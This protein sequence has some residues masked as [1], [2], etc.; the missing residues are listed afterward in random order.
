MFLCNQ[1][2]SSFGENVD[3]EQLAKLKEEY[4]MQETGGLRVRKIFNREYQGYS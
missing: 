2:L 3:T 4:I 1:Q